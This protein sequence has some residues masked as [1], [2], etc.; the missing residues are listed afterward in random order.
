M[1][2]WLTQK[3]KIYLLYIFCQQIENSIGLRGHGTNFV[4]C[5]AW[6]FV[7]G[8]GCAYLINITFTIVVTH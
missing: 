2:H 1:A 5:I 4:L 3:K 6:S 8:K 7:V